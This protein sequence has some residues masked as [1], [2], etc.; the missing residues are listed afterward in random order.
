M[1]A[2]LVVQGRPVIPVVALQSELEAAKAS[3]RRG[4]FPVG[5]GRTCR[6]TFTDKVRRNTAEALSIKEDEVA[7]ITD[8]YYLEQLLG[9]ELVEPDWELDAPFPDDLPDPSPQAWCLRYCYGLTRIGWVWYFRWYRGTPPSGSC[10]ST[11]GR[12]ILDHVRITGYRCSGK[13]IYQIGYIC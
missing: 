2:T 9:G 7:Y 13:Y 10:L 5:W 12:K 4:S 6:M 8:D 1:D 3:A 11:N